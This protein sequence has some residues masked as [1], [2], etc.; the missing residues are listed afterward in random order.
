MQVGLY[1]YASARKASL[2]SLCAY[3]EPFFKYP[4][5]CMMLWIAC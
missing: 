2:K 1:I 4:R 5:S 3:F